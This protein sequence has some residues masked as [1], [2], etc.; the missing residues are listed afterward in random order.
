MY[1]LIG[2]TGSG[3]SYLA[4]KI[5]DE[6]GCIFLRTQGRWW[7]Y[8]FSLLFILRHPLLARTIISCTARNTRGKSK[9]LKHKLLYILLNAF[10]KEFI[11]RNSRRDVLIDD[12]LLQY[13]PSM[14]EDYM[15]RKTFLSDI[16]LGFFSDRN[17]IH[18]S[19]STD[20]RIQRMKSRG[21]FLRHQLPEPERSQYAKIF[22]HNFS[23]M[24][25]EIVERFSI[26]E[27][28]NHNYV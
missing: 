6:R 21:R 23:V 27:I 17:V 12:G 14:Y 9:L 18:I 1:E 15:D 28:E 19:V 26:E 10:A 2:L 3:K 16:D 13:L 25:D 20:V 8:V 5:A 7:R 4:E 11:A 22:E 24:Y